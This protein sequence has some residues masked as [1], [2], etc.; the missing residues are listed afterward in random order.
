ML[1]AEK[2]VFHPFCPRTL[3]DSL[4]SGPSSCAPS[5]RNLLGGSWV[6]QEVQLD[7]AKVAW[8]NGLHRPPTWAAAFIHWLNLK[9]SMYFGRGHSW[10]EV[11]AK[12][13][14]FVTVNPISQLARIPPGV[15]TLQPTVR[16]RA[17]PGPSPLFHVPTNP[18]EGAKLRERSDPLRWWQ[19]STAPKQDLPV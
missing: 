4:T 9:C 10:E 18:S 1:S 11:G 13:Q 6:L 15:S 8:L 17:F 14:L 2:S 19:P 7:A 16:K 3:A 5:P 12:E